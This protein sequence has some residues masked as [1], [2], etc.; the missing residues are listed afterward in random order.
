MSQKQI[1][2]LVRV[3]SG[4]LQ[5]ES[6]RE[7]ADDAAASRRASWQQACCTW[8]LRGRADSPR[9]TKRFGCRRNLATFWHNNL[10]RE[11][12]QFSNRSSC[13][14]VFGR[15]FFG[16]AILVFSDFAFKT[17]TIVARKKKP[18]LTHISVAVAHAVARCTNCCTCRKGS[19]IALPTN[20][21]LTENEEK[22][23]T[24][25]IA[26]TQNIT[27]R[28]TSSIHTIILVEKEESN[29]F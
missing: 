22:M 11:S 4:K 7:S 2:L 13:W 1:F 15:S 27:A 23:P 19:V 9:S 5:A 16:Q 17:K 26:T 21:K 28:G 10:L 29:Q 18:F 8:S 25:K 12:V 20:R 14:D 24:R 6:V 3:Q